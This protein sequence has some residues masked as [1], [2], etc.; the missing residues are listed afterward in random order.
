MEFDKLSVLASLKTLFF[1]VGRLHVMFLVSFA[2][3]ISKITLIQNIFALCLFRLANNLCLFSAS[4]ALLSLSEF[5]NH[6]NVVSNA[7]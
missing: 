1:H 2:Y 3:E 7:S 4:Y 6:T 5:D